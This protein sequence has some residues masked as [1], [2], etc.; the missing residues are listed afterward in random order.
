MDRLAINDPRRLRFFRFVGVSMRF[1][2]VV[3]AAVATLVSFGPA[4]A[5]PT[6]RWW[7]GWGQGVAE[8]GYND[9]NGSSIYIACDENYPESTKRGVT[10]TVSVDAVNAAPNSEVT[11]IVDMD[12][13]SFRT[14]RDESIITT[15]SHVAADNFTALWQAMRGGRKVSYVIKDRIGN[16]HLKTFGL[17]GSSKALSKEGCVADFYK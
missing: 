11:F 2:A 5:E 13:F 16:S 7:S 4:L 10:I 3:W 6:A 1:K 12:S 15:N 8:Y 9:G 17:A 14:E